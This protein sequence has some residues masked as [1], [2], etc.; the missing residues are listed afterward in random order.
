MRYASVCDG[1]GAVHEAWMPLGMECAWVSEIDAFASA[2][3]EQRYGVTNLGD[4]TAIRQGE[5]HE[6]GAV[7]ILVG[8]TPCQSFSV[9]ACV[10]EGL[11]DPRG[12]LA[13]RFMQLVGQMRPQWVVWENVPGVLT[14][15]GGRD[16]GAILGALEEFGYGFSYRILDAQYFG[17]PQ[18]R[19][20]LFLVGSARG[21]ERAAEILFEQKDL[22]WNSGEGI[23][24]REVAPTGTDGCADGRVVFTKSRRAQSK[25]DCETW[26]RGYVAPTA[27]LFDCGDSRATTIVV[28]KNGLPRRL[29]PTE[30][31]RLQGFSGTHTDIEFRGR[32][33][34][35]TKR[36]GAVGNTMAVPVMRWIGERILAA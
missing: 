36:Y 13:L 5:I 21:P 12:N 7:D 20:R 25:S 2:V 17:V 3:C 4:M 8:G 33:A 6:R 18:R 29:T 35:D 1:I 32:P 22:P 10:R 31:E 24:E 28:E 34:P 30:F 23:E 9:A 11:S 26:V 27:T 19:R 15:N 16:F 14:A